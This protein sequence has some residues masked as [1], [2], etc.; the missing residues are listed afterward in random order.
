MEQ[1]IKDITPEQSVIEALEKGNSCSC[2]ICGSKLAKADF[3]ETFE[4]LDF[5]VVSG[6]NFDNKIVRAMFN[7][8]KGT[9]LIFCTICFYTIMV[10][11]QAP[12]DM[13]HEPTTT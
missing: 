3:S 1:W 10:N 5:S 9:I 2:S 11:F 4:S 6:V 13:K 12:V 7:P 8:M